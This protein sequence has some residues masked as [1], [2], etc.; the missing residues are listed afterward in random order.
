MFVTEMDENEF[1]D[2]N[3]LMLSK[4]PFTLAMKDVRPSTTT[5]VGWPFTGSAFT[6]EIRK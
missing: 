4:G 1:Y 5:M 6:I 3:P 2:H